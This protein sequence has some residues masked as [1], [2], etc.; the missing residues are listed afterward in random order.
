MLNGVLN[1]NLIRLKYMRSENI[2][3]ISELVT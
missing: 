3:I 2:I 1:R